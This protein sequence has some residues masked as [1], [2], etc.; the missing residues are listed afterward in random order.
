MEKDLSRLDAL[1]RLKSAQTSQTRDRILKSALEL[2]N[3]RGTLSV[4]THDIA[5]A[6]GLSAGNLYYHFENK[7]E[8]VREIFYRMEIFSDNQWWE[9]G[10]ANPRTGFTDFMRFFFGNLQKYRFFFREF[11]NLLQKDPVLARVWRD[12]YA[13]LFAAM[14]TAVRRW[15][16]A[17]ILKPFA[18]PE[19]IDAFIENCWIISC[20]SSSYIEA[21]NGANAGA[22]SV[23]QGSTHLVLRFLYPYHTAKGQKAMDLHFH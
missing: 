20:F 10:P 5:D 14:R 21:K 23:H 2:F 1:R 4:T 6:A 17:G 3:E 22:R 9:R 18:A 8:I 11:S 12:T 7:E 13:K 16:E 15:V 19:E